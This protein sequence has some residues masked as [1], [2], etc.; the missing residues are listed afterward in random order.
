MTHTA[1][2]IAARIKAMEV[3]IDRMKIDIANHE[4]DR[5]HLPYKPFS[6]HPDDAAHLNTLIAAYEAQR[7]EIAAKDALIAEA[8]EAVEKIR[9][10]AELW[11]RIWRLNMK[12]DP[13]AT[14]LAPR[15]DA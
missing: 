6:L 9:Q 3:W 4:S 1:D 7:A 10:T 11:T 13:I 15:E 14:A 8:R 5:P 12:L 2:E